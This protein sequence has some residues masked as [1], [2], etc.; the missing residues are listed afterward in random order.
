MVDDNKTRWLRLR[1]IQRTENLHNDRLRMQ[2]HAEEA[3]FAHMANLQ[4]RV[5]IQAKTIK[6]AFINIST[7]GS[8]FKR[9]MK[10]SNRWNVLTSLDKTEE[11]IIKSFGVMT[12][13]TWKGEKDTITPS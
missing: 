9:A 1:H 13:F 11:E 12:V 6:C 8:Y 4:R 10:S 2:L 7:D 3:V 5:F